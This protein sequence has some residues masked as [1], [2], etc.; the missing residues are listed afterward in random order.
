MKKEKILIIKTG[1][2]ETLDKEDNSRKVS[3][4]DVLRTTLLLNLYKK[5]HVTWVS[6]EEAFPLLKNNPYINKLLHFDALTIQQLRLERFDTLINLEKI[7][8]ICALSDEIDAW[9]KYGFRFNRESG[10]AEAYDKAFEILAVSSDS[11]LKKENIWPLQKLLYEMVGEKWNGEKYILGYKPKTKEIYD[12]GLNTKIG[13]KWPTKS[14]SIQ[15]WNMLERI[16]KKN[17]VKVSR[18]DKQDPEIL[19]NL[20]KY[21][22]WINSCKT[23]ISNDSLGLHLAI[24]L[25]KKTL[26]L[27][28][29][30]PYKEIH[31]YG[32]GEAILPEPIPDCMPCFKGICERGKNCMEDI[33]PER[34][35]EKYNPYK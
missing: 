17:S 33:S 34:V 2:S 14:W 10:E 25:E 12:V 23:I 15:N 18:Q 4:G 22:D 13:E 8:G 24:T 31:F 6:D 35:Y 11:K 28:G 27:L 21:I 26:G 1:Y 7:P 5:Y 16:L 20:E 9:K 30:T 3:L 29:P 19:K 32:K